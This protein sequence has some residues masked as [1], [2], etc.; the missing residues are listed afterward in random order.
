MGEAG[1]GAVVEVQ[2]GERRA[3]GCAAFNAGSKI[4]LRLLD[5]DPAAE[6][7]VDWLAARLSRAQALRA[8]LYDAPF[9]RLAHAEADGLPGVVIDRFGEAAV[10]QPNAAWAEARLPAL[11]EAL[12]AVTGVT[13]AWTGR[14]VAVMA[15]RTVTTGGWNPRTDSVEPYR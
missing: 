6:I 7:G 5:A 8:V 11:V 13:T 10:V 3:L 12:V 15:G 14:M 1:T 2:D 4:A 9:Y